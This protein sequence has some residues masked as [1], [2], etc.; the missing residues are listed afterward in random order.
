MDKFNEFMDEKFKY[1]VKV[2]CII[3]SER[4]FD[5]DFDFKSHFPYFI[6]FEKKMLCYSNEELLY[7]SGEIIFNPSQYK[8]MDL[9]EMFQYQDNI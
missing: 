5:I 7:Y 8:K 3:C 4:S 6:D 9:N 1:I 2:G